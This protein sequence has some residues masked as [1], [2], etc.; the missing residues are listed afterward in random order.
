M[1]DFTGKTVIVTGA[2]SGIGEA[3]AH[4]FGRQGAAVVMAD[5]DAQKNGAAADGVVKETGAKTLAVQCDVADEGGCARLVEQAVEQFDRVDVLINNAGVIAPGTILDLDPADFDRVMGINLRACFI[6]TQIVARHMVEEGTKGAIV[7]MSSLNAVLAIPNQVAYVTSK[8]GLQQLTKVSALGLADH[9]I[10]VNAVGPGSIMTDILKVVMT[11]DAARRNIL[12]RTPLRRVGDP[13]EVASV[14]LFLA[15]DMASYITGQTIFPD[16]GR[17]A[18][19][20][21]VPVHD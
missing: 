3:C 17:A 12:S 18:L 1:L 10:R 2:A 16:G 19:N 7:N 14:A 9:G 11:D 8:G 21:T 6:L 5:I 4:A 13:A 20:Y 15:S